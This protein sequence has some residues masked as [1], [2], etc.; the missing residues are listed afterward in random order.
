MYTTYL[1]KSQLSVMMENASARETDEQ[2]SVV[3]VDGNMKLRK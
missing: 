3:S 1:Y 2:G